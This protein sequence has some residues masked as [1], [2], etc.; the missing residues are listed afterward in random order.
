MRLNRPLHNA[1][2]PLL[3][4]TLLCLLLLLS[5]PV[6]ALDPEKLI[7]QYVL[8]VWGTERGMPQNSVL[9]LLQTRDGYIWAGTEEGLVR[10]DGARFQVF[11]KT[12]SA[13]RRNYVH[14]L[15][16][17]R[18]GSLWIGTFGGGLTRLKDGQFTT[19]TNAAGL[20]MNQVRT[21]AEGRDGSLWIGLEGAG[22]SQFK[23]GQ[24]TLPL[25]R[26]LL[27]PGIIRALLE[28][29]QGNLWLGTTNG[30]VKWNQQGRKLY[31]TAEGLP[32]DSVRALYEDS[33]GQLWIGTSNGFA[34]LHEERLTA[35]VAGKELPR[36]LRSVSGILEDSHQNLWLAAPGVGLLRYRAGK[37]ASYSPQNGAPNSQIENVIED[38][39]GNL[40]FSAI[41]LG[42][43]KLSDARFTMIGKP[44]GLSSDLIRAIQETRD[45]S[46]WLATAGGGLNRWRAGRNEVFAGELANQAVL[47]LHEGRD[48][49]L[50]L[51]TSAGEV[52]RYQEGRF[53]TWDHRHGLH[54][55]M[56]SSLAETPDGTLWIGSS[57][58]GLHSLKNGRITAVKPGPEVLSDTIYTLQVGREGALWIGTNRG[59]LQYRAGQFTKYGAS[60]GLP[61]TAVNAIFE[62]AEGRLWVG[63]NGAGLY[64]LSAGW[65]IFVTTQQGL[66]DDTIWAIL[67]DGA[68]SLWLSSNRGIARLSQQELNAYAAGQR[69]TIRSVVYGQAD[70]MRN[71][72]CNGQSNPVGFRTRDGRLWFATIRGAAIIDPAHLKSNPLAPPVL[73]EQLLVGKRAHP[74]QAALELAPGSRDLA[75]HYTALS[76]VVPEAV[77]FRYILEG[78]DPGWEDVGSRRVAYYNQ[79]PPGRYRFRVQARNN[80]GVWNESGAALEF[81]LLPRFW[82]TWWF[83]AACALAAL[84]LVI[85]GYRWRLRQLHERE[86][87][88][89]H[90][91]AERTQE[92]ESEIRGHQVTEARLKEQI[93]ERVRADEALAE[94]HQFL[95]QVLDIN[96]YYIF[97]KD[98][99]GRFTLVNRAMAEG[100]G[101]TVE[102]MIGCTDL[103]VGVPAADAEKYRQADLQVMDSLEEAFILEELNV[104]AQGRVRW[105]QTVKRPILNREGKSNLM[106]GVAFDITERKQVEIEL[107][108]YAAKLAQTNLELDRQR[109]ELSRA[110]EA[111][112]AAARAK[113]EFLANMSHEIRTPM[114]GIIGM[115]ELTLTTP[116]T[117]EQRDYLNTV[118]VSANALLTLLNDI[119]DFSKIEAGKLN[120]EA[121]PFRLRELLE[122]TLKTLALEA[123]KKSLELLGEIDSAV[124][125]HLVGDPNRLRQ[126]LINLLGN[127]LK[128]TE[129]GSVSLR[130]QVEA[131][132]AE[133]VRLHVTV[134]DTGIGIPADKLK[135]IFGS[136]EQVDAST[137]RKYGGTGLGLSISAQL[138]SL[139]GGEIHVES[140]YGEGSQFHFNVQL[141]LA[142]AE[143]QPNDVS[144]RTARLAPAVA[145]ARHPKTSW[146]VLLVDDN[147]VN[148]RLATLMLEKNGHQVSLAEDGP[149]ALEVCEHE[150]FDVVLLDI[151]MPTLNGFEVA[152]ALRRLDQARGRHIP[153][154]AMTAQAMNG[155]REA[156]LAAGMDDYVSKPLRSAEL[157]AKIERVVATRIET[158]EL[159]V[160]TV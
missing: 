147:A 99:Q 44:E 45:G 100:Y 53:T 126:I 102:N 59:L 46:V 27:P 132:T 20:A 24:F 131:R 145:A 137:T 81:Q 54:A 122:S 134:A 55:E 92:L 135:T 52:K 17:T 6:W 90:K 84:G 60:V 154:I 88:L 129:R 8:S 86:E 13:L 36:S 82:Q 150:H 65:A 130:V 94:Q 51:G 71:H 96:P 47:S 151:Q 22:I 115:T 11:D 103:E 121:T 18:D 39:E 148:R 12:N 32:S 48:G 30:L 21:L 2:L 23:D 74:L 1:L 128:F 123:Q 109:Q 57:I 26:E 160:S 113:S 31:T 108:E 156:C 28:D 133:Q 89:K 83:F 35:W 49:S 104:D 43:C 80:D 142:Q 149:T 5:P 97:V 159:A 79:L 70:G 61:E 19:Y 72:E 143:A 3:T 138:I 110:K 40:W 38:R 76:F 41:G 29:R 69:S 85:V 101:T 25:S 56:I 139:M 153:I 7:T 144:P 106:M 140:V 58:S 87:T 125:D 157:L 120:L 141:K 37:F 42:L 95:R 118:Q 63:T 4:K 136:F 152:A 155:D 66:F 105:M 116:L 50:W 15:C 107:Q 68:G 78:Y 10:F 98:R 77:R 73:I 111:A 64:R 112:E 158:A 119:L 117:E 114:N 33:R 34:L 16:E 67:A 93:T 9:T 62:D 91:V 14:T 146:Q 124:P 75:I 127:A